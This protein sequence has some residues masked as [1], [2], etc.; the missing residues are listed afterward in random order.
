[1]HQLCWGMF[2]CPPGEIGDLGR[3][4]RQKAFHQCDAGLGVLLSLHEGSLLDVLMSKWG[5]VAN[6]CRKHA[7]DDATS[8]TQLAASMYSC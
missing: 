5:Q 6:S 4:K 2:L 8:K 7:L 1:M 3:V